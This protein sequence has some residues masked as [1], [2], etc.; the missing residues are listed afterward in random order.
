MA[1]QP[2]LDTADQDYQL[3]VRAVRDLISQYTVAPTADAQSVASRY[4]ARVE[5]QL[6]GLS[7]GQAADAIQRIISEANEDQLRTLVEDLPL[8]GAKLGVPAD[9]VNGFLAD[10]IPGVSEKSAEAQSKGRKLAV[11]GPESR[12]L[13]PRGQGRCP[14]VSSGTIPLTSP[15]PRQRWSQLGSAEAA[16]GG[17]EP[18][19]A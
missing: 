17:A 15:D 10:A 4:V 19:A 16:A 13:V 5:K 9:V 12:Q 7:P 2:A 6:D 14:G 8:I 1:L 3:A 11:L 18:I